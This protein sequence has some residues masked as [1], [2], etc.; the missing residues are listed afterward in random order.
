MMEEAEK[1][2]LQ[3]LKVI[4]DRFVALASSAGPIHDSRTGAAR[5]YRYQPRKIAAWLNPVDDRTR[6]HPRPGHRGQRLSP[7]EGAADVGEGARERDPPH[8]VRHR[9][10]RADHAAGDV[11]DRPAAGRRARTRRRSTA[12]PEAV[13]AAAERGQVA[14]ATRFTAAGEPRRSG[15]GWRAPDVQKARA[16][17]FEAVWDLVWHR[18]V[19][20]F[21]TVAFTLLLVTMP[22]WISRGVERRDPGGRP[23]VDRRADP[24]GRRAAARDVPG[25][26]RHLREQPVLHVPAGRLHLGD[27]ALR[28]GPGTEA[29]R[30]RPPHLARGR[31]YH[32]ARAPAGREQSGLARFRNAANY[33]RWMQVFKWRVLP[34]YVFL[35]IIVFVA[36]LARRRRRH[37]GL[38]AVAGEWHGAVHEPRRE[39]PEVGAVRQH[40]PAGRH[41]P[42]RA[43]ERGTRTSGIASSCA[44]TRTIPGST[45][46]TRPIRRACA[47]AT[48]AW[49]ASSAGRSAA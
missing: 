42:R 28:R 1:A 40:V 46:A 14:V 20:Y 30:S 9:S 3:H 22:I 27:D 13:G 24:R 43:P 19:A 45:A 8:L 47:R 10:L 2:G 39:R 34:D 15:T 36:G 38:P 11:H 7:A 25:L 35:P 37:A 41:L 4:K 31:R 17:A 48:W 12:S 26:D 49:P 18:R 32:G 6:R 5:Y 21:I 29:A 16:A 23:H 44:S 33:Q